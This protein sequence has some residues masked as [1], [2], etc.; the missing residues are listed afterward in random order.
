MRRRGLGRPLRRVREGIV[1]LEVRRV[2]GPRGARF[3]ESRGFHHWIFS[4]TVRSLSFL[5][6]VDGITHHPSP[7]S[8]AMAWRQPREL[9]LRPS[10]QP[11][12]TLPSQHLLRPAH[13]F[14]PRARRLPQP[15]H[16]PERLVLLSL[17]HHPS[18]RTKPAHSSPPVFFLRRDSRVP[19]RPLPRL[20]LPPR[21]SSLNLDLL[22]L[23]PPLQP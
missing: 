7:R 3:W 5:L 1:V 10:L 8:G 18:A 13:H 21:L 22:L 20:H 9:L 17:R 11:A 6:L 15:S 23:L 4:T 16:L 2:R 19:S 14:R 12:P